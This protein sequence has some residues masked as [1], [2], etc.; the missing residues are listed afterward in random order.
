MTIYV[1][2]IHIQHYTAL[3]IKKEL[4]SQPH[5][6]FSQSFLDRLACSSSFESIIGAEIYPLF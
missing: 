6:S 5:Q 4:I 2:F 1:R 3:A